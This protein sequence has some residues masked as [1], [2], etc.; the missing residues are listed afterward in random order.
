MRFIKC[1]S[2]EKQH[3]QSV[4]L[5]GIQRY[6]I[7]IA[8][9]L[10]LLF[11]ELNVKLKYCPDP[12]SLS[13]QS[14]HTHMNTHTLTPIYPSRCNIVTCHCKAFSDMLNN[15]LIILSFLLY[16]ITFTILSYFPVSL[17][18]IRHW[19]HLRQEPDHFILYS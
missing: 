2:E 3:S 9:T 7:L 12:T 8:Y 14:H 15:M 10:E 19:A 1:Y 17:S 6:Q 18:S 4:H 16:Y 5:R 11:K 13:S